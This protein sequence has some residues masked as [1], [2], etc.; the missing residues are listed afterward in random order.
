MT[1]RY[2]RDYFK[3]WYH[4]RSTRVSSHAEVRRKVTLAVAMTE[5]F[6][7]RRI[8]TVLDIGCGEGAWRQHL[9]AI[10]PRTAYLGFDSSDYAVERFG[11]KR[12]IRKA[13][14][15][16]LSSHDLG[17]YDLVVCSD[18]MHYVRDAELQRGIDTIASATDGVAYLEVL[19][20]EDDITGDMDGFIRRPAAW[21]RR[22]FRS[23]GLTETGPYCWLSPAF[24]DAV[25]ELEQL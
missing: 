2:D 1:K 17:V 12:N 16:E 10:R 22:L 19:T 7:R 21:Y 14:F 3:Q 4:D 23:A 8:R 18:V 25:A 13:A 11:S 6:L 9:L 15:G 5:Y 24:E 20:R